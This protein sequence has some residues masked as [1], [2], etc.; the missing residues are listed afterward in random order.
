MPEV[1][2]SVPRLLSDCVEGRTRLSLEAATVAGAFEQIRRQWPTL[3]THVFTEA[4]V[5][6]P[7]V[8]VLHNGKATR[9]MSDLGVPLS[10]GDELTVL[11][12]VSGG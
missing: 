10:P 3:A 7:H 1:T 2:L 9:W 5:V 6:R 11:Q 8:L 12:A 4:G